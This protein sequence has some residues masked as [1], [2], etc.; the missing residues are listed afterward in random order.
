L[1]F[2][3][4]REKIYTPN[5]GEQQVKNASNVGESNVWES[6]NVYVNKGMK[7]VIS[8]I[9]YSKINYNIIC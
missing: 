7:L 6:N 4:S 9:F 8:L 2:S 5:E 1:L 3:M